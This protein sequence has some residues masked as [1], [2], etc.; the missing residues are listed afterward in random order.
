[1][2]KVKYK[3]SSKVKRYKVR[4]VAKNYSQQKGLDYFETFSPVAKMVTMRSVVGLAILLAGTC[5]K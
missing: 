5:F 2:F 4:L 1:M 3:A